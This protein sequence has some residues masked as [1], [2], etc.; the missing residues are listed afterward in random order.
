MAGRANATKMS[1][2][3]GT[4][5]GIVGPDR[6][7][8]DAAE[9]DFYSSDLFFAGPAAAIVIQPGTRDELAAA[10]AAITG[11]GVAVVARG[12]G[13]SYTKG[14]VPQKLECVV[15]D[16]RRVGRIVEISRDDMLATVEAGCTWAALHAALEPHGLRVPHFGPASGR[17]STIGGGLSQ[18]S[19]FF[20]SG[21][22]GT[23]ADCVLSLEAVLA[24]GEVLRT[25]SAAIDGGSPF[26]RYHGPDLGGLFL[27]DCGALGIKSAATLRLQRTPL[28]VASASFNF[29][30]FEAMIAAQAQIARQ[31]IAAECLGAGPFVPTPA[32]HRGASP[33][34]GP[35]ALPSLHLVVEGR[36]EADAAARL[37][38]LRPL[39]G[40][41]GSEIDPVVPRAFRADPFGFVH[42]PLDA[43]GRLQAW[44]HGI[45]P[46]SRA[47]G[48]YAALLA[49][50]DQWAEEMAHHA[51]EASVSS[52]VAGSALLLEPVLY[53]RDT[54]RP[55]HLRVMPGAH[56]ADGKEVHSANPAATKAVTE[57][58]DGLRDLFARER[59]AHMQIGKYYS[60]LG[61]LDG[62]ARA[63][64]EA[65]K[66]V[67]DPRGL[68]N[69]GAL[70]LAPG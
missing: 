60:Y 69:P 40:R 23:A 4:L 38:G 36:D 54:P 66:G 62:T 57:L 42:S 64:V 10:V 41:E 65:I 28:S 27:G 55:V 32:R 1:V 45:V 67:L 12:G 9:R 20:G 31:Q 14:Y 61:G 39:A 8:L 43:Q 70:G 50:L 22:A 52:L 44:T 16:T 5:Q 49:T 25:G 2:L 46:L 35:A 7:I 51:I 47:D 17:V 6:V 21:T 30:T 15:V 18:N 34:G 13:L 33:S 68:M 26:F 24:D 59:A 3:V 56:A 11:S 53:W 58:R 48:L 37:D 19:V 63:A 29:P